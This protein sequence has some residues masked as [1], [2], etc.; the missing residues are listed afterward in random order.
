MVMTTKISLPESRGTWI[1]SFT[2]RDRK[3]RL[4]L[5]ASGAHKLYPWV[6]I[7]TIRSWVG[8][9]KS[10]FLLNKQEGRRFIQTKIVTKAVP[11]PP[12]N[13]T[14]GEIRIRVYLKDDIHIIAEKMA[15]QELKQ[16]Q[17]Q[18]QSR[19]IHESI[20]LDRHGREWLSDVQAVKRWGFARFFLG[21]WSTRKSRINSDRMALRSKLIANAHHLQSRGEIRVYL[22]LDIQDIIA[23]KESK[24]PGTGKGP[25]AK[26]FRIA[27]AG[28][29]KQSITTI[30][31]NAGQPP[32]TGYVID[33]A[34]ALGIGEKAAREGLDLYAIWERGI[35]SSKLWRPRPDSQNGNGKNGHTSEA[36]APSPPDA[37]EPPA[38][39]PEPTTLV[40]ATDPRHQE[41]AP[42]RTR[43]KLDRGRPSIDLDSDQRVWDAW[44]TGQHKNKKELARNLGMEPKQ[45]RLALHRHR[46]RLTRSS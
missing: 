37:Q 18:K 8:K 30:L 7:G 17:V 14:W 19:F 24:T 11:P 32:N 15:N 46:V 40:V 39:Q 38:G 12:G 23:G 25:N 4:W 9:R 3:G 13:N 27:A 22:A 33:Q 10:R 5:T 35:D 26:K 29:L 41:S 2:F 34:Q 6:C 16:Q 21:Y 45:V 31:K 28:R 44:K 20:H 1:D 36:V 42:A 43:K